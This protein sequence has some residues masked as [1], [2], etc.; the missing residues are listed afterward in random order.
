MSTLQAS[1]YGKV[2]PE[3]GL[4]RNDATRKMELGTVVSDTLGN[5]Y[6]YVK[7]S[8]ALYKGG[9]VTAVA[10]AAWP[11]GVLIDG[12]L[13]A[14]DA[15][16]K[17]HIDTFAV[18]NTKNQFAGYWL[19]IPAAEATNT[20][21]GGIAHKIK[22]HDAFFT[23]AGDSTEGDIYLEDNLGEEWTDGLALSLY[24]PYLM[25]N[26][27]AGTEIIMGV[28]I[29]TIAAGSYGFVQVGGHCPT[30]YCGGTTSA[31]IVINEPIVPGAT[32]VT[33]TIAGAGIGMAGS[34]EADMHEAALSPVI[35]L[36]NL[37]ADTA[38]WV[39]AFIKGLV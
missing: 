21:D 4:E 18:A 37:A 14:T 34:A 32:V 24:N 25:E 23:S 36:Q 31:A 7:A 11:V 38:G 16:N 35:A 8:E 10:K 17:I 28:G 15:T 13:D 26:T 33:D 3:G 20:A 30:V 19:S 2:P 5:S 22:C 9:L 27:D 6:R 39:E 1:G 29:C 12:T